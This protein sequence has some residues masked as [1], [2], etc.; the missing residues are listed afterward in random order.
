M[1]LDTVELVME[2]EERFGIEL[3]DEELELDIRTVGDLEQLI[4]RRYSEKCSTTD[5][6]S[7]KA[8]YRLRKALVEELGL[9]RKQIKPD[10]PTEEVFPEASRIDT[11]TKIS[12]KA[13]VEF[14]DLRYPSIYYNIIGT[15]TIAFWII[16]SL[17]ILFF[18]FV[19]SIANIF[20]VSIPFKKTFKIKICR[21]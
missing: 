16:I 13:Q 10:T 4:S 20:E 12:K 3:P 14:P 9:E 2:V 11:W 18:F 5:C 8:F 21:F 15:L 1:G 17:M 7:Q 6:N 19:V